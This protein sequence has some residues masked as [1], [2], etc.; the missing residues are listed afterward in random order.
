MSKYSIDY[1]DRLRIHE[2]RDFAREVGVQR[3]TTLKKGELIDKINEAFRNPNP[4]TKKKQPEETKKSESTEKAEDLFAS[5]MSEDD[6]LLIKFVAQAEARD[7]ESKA[8]KRMAGY[9]IENSNNVP[10]DYSS[11]FSFK[12]SQ[13]Q[14]DYSE[15][16]NYSIRG[17]YLHLFSQGHG[18]LKDRDLISEEDVIYVPAAVVKKEKLRSGMYLT[19]KIRRL[20]QDKP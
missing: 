4:E 9:L 13:N 2:L 10:S 15:D 18:K 20:I 16:N 5:L 19:G 8:K 1:I 14:A 11:V 3:P 6:T 17:G 7:R 12:V